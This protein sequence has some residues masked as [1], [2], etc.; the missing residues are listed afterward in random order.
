V[1]RRGRRVRTWQQ[2]TAQLQL[3]QCDVHGVS[4]R[5]TVEQPLGWD[6]DLFS[7]AS[8]VSPLGLFE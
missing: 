2:L 5:G 8:D 4:L 3:S 7:L 1:Q 6:K